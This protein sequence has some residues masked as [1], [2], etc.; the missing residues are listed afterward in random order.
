[1]KKMAVRLYHYDRLHYRIRPKREARNY[2][3][4]TSLGNTS[5]G[6]R[7]M[8]L[9]NTPFSNRVHYNG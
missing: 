1:M 7:K 6:L 3:R 8:A 2:K 4:N 9:I 5:L